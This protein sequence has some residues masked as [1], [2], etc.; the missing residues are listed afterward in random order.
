[1]TNRLGGKLSFLLAGALAGGVAATL[2]A[3]CSGKRMRAR[4]RIEY[5]AK[6]LSDV[7]KGLRRRRDEL[8][9][10]SEKIVRGAQ[11]LFA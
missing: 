8:L 5:G 2:A 4:R 3:P 11:T 9:S 6:R 10:R 1:M 7:E